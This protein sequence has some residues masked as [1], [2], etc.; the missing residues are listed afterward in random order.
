MITQLQLENEAVYTPVPIGVG[1]REYLARLSIQA[2]KPAGSSYGSQAFKPLH[3]FLY[4]VVD[5]TTQ[6]IVS[7]YLS[8]PLS[9]QFTNPVVFDGPGVWKVPAQVSRVKV[10]M[11][12][13]GGPGVPTGPGA[14]PGGGGAFL[15]ALV[16]VQ[17]GDT[18]TVSLS[19]PRGPAQPSSV[20]ATLVFSSACGN[21]KHGLTGTFGVC[22]RHVGVVDNPSLMGLGLAPPSSCRALMAC[23]GNPMPSPGPGIYGG[24][25][26]AVIGATIKATLTPGAM[27]GSQGGHGG[28]P[29]G[30]R[31]GDGVNPPAVP[32]GGGGATGSGGSLGAPGR[33]VIYY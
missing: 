21:I 18:Y 14:S 2:T 16:D 1:Q 33:V 11:W 28:G 24:Q 12:G 4:V 27:P 30:G 10:H 32:G 19:G 26:G 20:D 22:G 13:P 6:Q 7:C 8:K 23:G 3:A 25:A 9:D 29:D 31:G 5:T 15:E 17:P